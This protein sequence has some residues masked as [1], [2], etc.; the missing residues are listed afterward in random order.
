MSIDP[1][2]RKGLHRAM[3]AIDADADGLLVEARR[4]GRR[5]VITYRAVAGVAFVTALVFLV[6]LAPVLLDAL[7]SQHRQP[8]TEPPALSVEGTYVTTITDE[9]AASIGARDAAGAWLLTL[10][11]DGVMTLASLDNADL[12]RATTPYQTVGDQIITAALT[13]DDCTGVGRY[14][15]SRTGSTLTFERVSD[16]CDLRVLILSSQ[17]WIV[18]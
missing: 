3:S 1:R 7:G 16:P 4:R 13:G 10:R 11:G 2:V 8:A 12:G 14:I 17:M 15:W 9:D 6:L 18:R 5:R